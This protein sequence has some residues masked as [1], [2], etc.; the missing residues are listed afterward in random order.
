LQAKH[1]RLLTLGRFALVSA[2]GDEESLSRRRRKLALLCVLAL[3]PRPYSRD[4]LADLFWGEEDDE[5]ARHSLSDA[6]SHLRRLLGREAIATRCANVEL[7]ADARL[8]VDAVEFAAACD[9]RDYARAVALYGGPFLD[10]IY[11]ERSPRFESWVS[12]ERDRLARLFLTAAAA[13]CTR[14]A[15]T[16]QW[17]ACAT[18]AS[19]W[20]EAEPLSADAALHLLDAH[21]AAGT[22]DAWLAA[23]GEYRALTTRLAREYDAR[24]D[25]R[26]AAR[27]AE[28]EARVAA[29]ED[30]A[31]TAQ[32]QATHAAPATQAAVRDATDRSRPHSTVLA[33]PSSDAMA[34]AG[35]TPGA[36]GRRASRAAR[37]SRGLVALG[38]ALA[39]IGVTAYAMARGRNDIASNGQPV[40]AIA[41]IQNVR[42]DTAI[43]WLQDGLEQMIAADLSRSAAVSVV[44]PSRVRDVLAR[45]E[46]AGSAPLSSDEAVQLGRQ[47][48]ATWVATGNIARSDDAYVVNMSLRDVSSSA[49]VNLFTLTGLDVLALADEAASHILATAHAR[50][51]GP[52]LADVETANLDAYQH[53]V[54]AVQAQGE[55]RATDR[56]RELDAAIAEDSGFVSALLARMQIAEA[57]HDRAAVQRLGVAFRRAGPRI[58]E[59]DRMQQAAY[60]A[61]HNGEHARAE[62]L[63]RALVERF[64]HDPRAYAALADVYINHGRWVAA[65]SVLVRE[66]SLDSLATMA[67]DGP[68]APCTAFGGLVNVRVTAGD[69]RGAEH[70]ARRWVALQP[71]LPAAWADLATVLALSGEYDAG[72]AAARRASTLGADDAGA[73]SLLEGRILLMARRYDAVDSAIAVWRTGPTAA[74]REN[75]FDLQTMVERERGELRASNRTIARWVARYPGDADMLLMQGAALGRLGKFAEAREVIERHVHATIPSDPASPLVPRTGDWAR[76]FSWGHA[77]EADALRDARDTTLLRVLADSIDAASARSYYGRDWHLADHVRGL[78]AMQAGRYGEAAGDF[79]VARWGVAGWT[80]TVDA[81]ARAQLALGRSRDAIITLRHGYETLPDAMGRYEPRSELDLL[82]AVA[83]ERAGMRDSSAVYAGYVRRAWRDADPEVKA[84]LALLDSRETAAL[85][86]RSASHA[87]VLLGRADVREAAR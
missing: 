52:H 27:A 3:A 35:G 17:D 6:L 73:Y 81:L 86:P 36:P 19:R 85:A 7:S 54:R 75:A 76:A 58:T 16:K 79:E 78:I 15:R 14:L 83:F 69:L 34:T 1:F 18:L 13:E 49:T 8:A 84:E 24:P 23:L 63:S 44:A 9:T 56:K 66:L 42:G 67:G 53:Y 45:E 37:M 57:E 64:P 46:R 50:E 30:A 29:S 10:G 20:L 21:A 77:I 25:A 2:S 40:V 62:Q 32:L 87:S 22:R 33:E 5:R 11:I 12:R 4:V 43:A 38:G 51:P 71:E 31:H 61:L 68:C 41:A 48:D 55:G 26:V 74:Y 80:R 72:L 47:L 60:D 82:M 70:A 39:L 65:D 59:W 28:L